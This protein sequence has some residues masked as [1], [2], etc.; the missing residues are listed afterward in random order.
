MSNSTY[1]SQTQNPFQGCFLISPCPN[2]DNHS[3]LITLTVMIH[4]PEK[5][6]Y[7]FFLQTMKMSHFNIGPV[8][9]ILLWC[10]LWPESGRKGRQLFG[11]LKTL[12]CKCLFVLLKFFRY[13]VR[14]IALQTVYHFSHYGAH[15]THFIPI[16]Y[17]VNFES[18]RTPLHIT[19]LLE[20]VVV[21]YFTNMCNLF[22]QC[23]IFLF[24]ISIA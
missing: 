16:F 15:K 7:I 10:Y 8:K 11:S 19:N 17:R 3:C 13:H 6:Q 4:Y 9:I 2:C 22:V 24:F 23:Q 20:K 1:L 14:N 18:H 5:G 12:C 21:R